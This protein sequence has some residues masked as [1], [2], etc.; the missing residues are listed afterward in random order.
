MPRPPTIKDEQI[1]A[2]A[3]EV[4][5]EKGISATTA[6]VARR[7]GIAE[8]S[9]FNRFPTKHD[10]FKAAMLPSS[11]MPDWVDRLHHRPAGEDA[12]DA[13]VATGIEGVNFFR[14]ILPLIMMSWSN[15]SAS[16]LPE[17]LTVAD[18][19]P[20]RILAK[21]TEFF[22]AEMKA[23][24]MRKQDPEI[25]AR[26]FL[27]AVQNYAFFEVLMKFHARTLIEQE[28]YVRGFVKLLWSGLDPTRAT[29]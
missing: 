26:T 8:G 23:K 17:Q 29:R 15:A 6:E 14:T 11:E 21:L 7:A 13:L 4:F 5:L 1:L 24:R 25:V 12:L 28:E 10:L 18:P 16:G 20:L 27:A 9:I 22:A 3:R 19:P 2:A